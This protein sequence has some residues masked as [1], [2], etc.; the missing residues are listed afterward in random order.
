MM[1]TRYTWNAE[2]PRDCLSLMIM[3]WFPVRDRDGGTYDNAVV[4]AYVHLTCN[5]ALALIRWFAA[6][7]RVN[8]L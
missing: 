5:I 2:E 6:W 7:W 4:I 3:R 8:T 1:R